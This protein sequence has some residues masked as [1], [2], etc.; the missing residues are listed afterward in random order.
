MSK[1]DNV[2]KLM[3]NISDCQYW[4]ADP[5]RKHNNTDFS[6]NLFS[7]KITVYE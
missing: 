3:T 5:E 7:I 4:F 1:M 6:V 2:I